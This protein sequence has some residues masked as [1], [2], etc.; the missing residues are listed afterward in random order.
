MATPDAQQLKGLE[1]LLAAARY[2][3]AESLARA[4]LVRFPEHGFAWSALGAALLRTGRAAQAL[5]PMRIAASL[6]PHDARPH[7]A[8]GNALRSLGHL[9]EAVASQARAVQI[10]PSHAKAWFGLANAQRDLGRLDE[11]VAAYRRS[12]AEDP[13]LAKACLNL[14]NALQELGRFAEAQQSYR[15]ALGIQPD[16]PAALFNLHSAL[17]CTD[18]PVAAIACLHQAVSLNPGDPTFRFFLGVLL[19]HIGQPG[20]AEPHWRMLESGPAVGRARLDAWRYLKSSARAAAPRLLA[21]S[22]QTFQLAVHAAAREGLVLEFGVRHGK[23]IRQIAA[24]VG[25]PV[26]G[27]DSFAGLP[28]AWHREPKGSYSTQGRIPNVPENVSLHVGWFDHTL[29]RFLIEHPGGVRLLNIDCDIYSSTKTVLGLLAPRIMPGSV[30][31]FDE[32]IGNEFWRQDEFKAFQ[33]AVDEHGWQYEY[34]GYSFATKQV[35]VRI[36]AT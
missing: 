14:G 4:L 11:A 36:L 31:V 23:S 33:E 21:S 35:V 12:L 32:Y 26:H 18:E 16:W 13:N 6:A 30:I 24:M 2:A 9:D 29:P 1:Q 25:Q 20:A 7:H 19:D 5:E 27:F 34:L 3:E 28:E 22:V 10:Q 17:L 15:R 8:L